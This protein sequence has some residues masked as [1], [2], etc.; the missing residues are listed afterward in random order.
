M[1]DKF[2]TIFGACVNARMNALGWVQSNL[3]DALGITQASVSK[4]IASEDPGYKL[5]ARY[6]K[7]LKCEPWELIK[8]PAQDPTDSE[9][10]SQ[11]V[12]GITDE[13]VLAAVR[14]LLKGFSYSVPTVD[15]CKRR[16]RPAD[17]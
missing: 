16:D 17:E 12:R 13:T 7:A 2:Q 11:V 15:E 5:I 3:A 4:A 8:P 14:S 1:P 9:I 10:L 6:A